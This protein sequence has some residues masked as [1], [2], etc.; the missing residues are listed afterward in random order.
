MTQE[1][2]SGGLS[3]YLPVPNLH[4]EL[5]THV[6]HP[7]ILFSALLFF[8]LSRNRG[9]GW[10]RSWTALF[11][12]SAVGYVL[13]DQFFMSLYVPNRYTRYSMAVILALWHAH[14]WDRVLTTIPWRLLR[15]GALVALLG[16]G[17]WLFRDTFE[18]GKDTIDREQRSA[19]CRFIASLPEKILVAGHPRYMD[20]IPIQSRRS[21]LCNYK[22]AHPWFSTY[23]GEIKQRTEATFNA[24]YATDKASIN[25]LA[26]NY[27]VTHLVVV[28]RHFS[29]RRIR[30]ERIYVKP[31]SS[32][33]KEY[34][35]GKGRFLLEDP[36][37]ESVVYKDRRLW[38]VALP[39]K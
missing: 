13:A 4:E 31:F 32:Y 37:P 15:Y 21:V 5:L 36:P 29:R 30:E 3:D 14:N 11:L 2:Y 6:S 7:F 16:M 34:A 20:D 17:G 35:R 18:Q 9:V 10:K 38:I 1:M 26:E 23:Y 25:H 19:M 8:L 28:K 39:L 27:G 12:A 33:I 24:L 22:M